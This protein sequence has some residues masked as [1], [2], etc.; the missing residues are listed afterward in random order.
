MKQERHDPED[1]LGWVINS[2]P[3]LTFVYIRK[4]PLRRETRSFAN[5]EVNEA[6]HRAEC[7]AWS[8]YCLGCTHAPTPPFPDLSTPLQGV[9][10]R[11]QIP[12]K[13]SHT[14]ECC[15]NV[16][17]QHNHRSPLPGTR[18]A[19]CPLPVFRHEGE[20]MSCV[21]QPGSRRPRVLAVTFLPWKQSP[22]TA[23]TCHQHPD[24]TSIRRVFSV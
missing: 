23:N 8:W 16:K 5:P 13:C 10:Y 12:E 9:L 19:P 1:C 7:K 17:Q 2:T 11:R 21:K 6:H 3:L 18:P 24:T 4:F 14:A 20:I 15:T 22:A